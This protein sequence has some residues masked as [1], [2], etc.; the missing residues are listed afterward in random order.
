MHNAPTMYTCNMIILMY[1]QIEIYSLSYHKCSTL[2]AAPEAHRCNWC[3]ICMASLL[4]WVAL[5][6][7]NL[8]IVCI[9]DVAGAFS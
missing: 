3:R 7:I 8:H 1:K 2:T 9:I 4:I 5:A 6:N